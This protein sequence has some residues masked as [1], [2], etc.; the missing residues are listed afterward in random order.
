MNNSI[1]N[2]E[3]NTLFQAAH[4][5]LQN[6]EAFQKSDP[7]VSRSSKEI[8]ISINN[9]PILKGKDFKTTTLKNFSAQMNHTNKD[10]EGFKD[11]IALALDIRANPKFQADGKKI[12][13]AIEALKELKN[14]NLLGHDHKEL[15]NYDER[16]YAFNEKVDS[17]I[18][19]LNTKLKKT[20]HDS[21]AN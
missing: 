18:A 1:T 3:I 9:E 16:E 8:E 15:R 21:T 17:L 13:E 10:F 4:A 14:I 7:L 2:E 6:D 20:I 19:A 11:H 5:K 12:G